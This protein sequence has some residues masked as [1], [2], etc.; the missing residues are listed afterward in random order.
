MSRSA[1]SAFVLVLSLAACGTSSPAPTTTAAPP[2]EQS[3]GPTLPDP[4]TE[5]CEALLDECCPIWHGC[6]HVHVAGGDSAGSTVFQA[7]DGTL[8]RSSR[9]CGADGTCADHCPGGVCRPGVVRDLRR[10]DCSCMSGPPTHA[11]YECVLASGSCE[12][13]ALP[14]ADLTPES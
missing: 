8:Y 3:P 11:P 13:R 1:L 5:S 7:D 6:V 9:P 14:A 2:T 12:Q 10:D 4:S